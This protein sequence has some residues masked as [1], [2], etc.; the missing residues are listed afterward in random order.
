M[1]FF[2]WN[3]KVNALVIVALVL[4]VLSVFL[5]MYNK[6]KSE[7]ATDKREKIT[8]KWILYMIMAF[9]GNA[10]VGIV[11]RTQQMVYNGQHG[12]MLMFY[13][14][15]IA[16]IVSIVDFIRVDKTEL[17]KISKKQTAYP[18]LAGITNFIV[19]LIGLY[20]VSTPLSTNIIYPVLG[21]GCLI[22]VTIS[23]KFMFKE[24]M[25]KLQWVGVIVGAVAIALLSI[26][27]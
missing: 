10:G 2:F 6:Q 14:T 17:A 12:N 20:F 11:S 25:T 26:V 5:C 7:K 16:V 27:K 4:V 13:G 21:V 15:M 3:A 23:S 19:N 9:V 18:V 8:L 24:K 1:G 22:L